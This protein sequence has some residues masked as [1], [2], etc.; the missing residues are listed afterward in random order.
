[1]IFNKKYNN[2]DDNNLNEFWSE[3]NVNYDSINEKTLE[4]KKE[5]LDNILRRTDLKSIKFITKYYNI[6]V[7]GN[8]KDDY[9]K[10]IVDSGEYLLIY[11]D[12]FIKRKKRSVDEFFNH[13]IIDNKTSTAQSTISKVF[14]I[15]NNN[16]SDLFQILTL[17]EWNLKGSGYELK[18]NKK[19]KSWDI[20]EKLILNESETTDFTE[21]LYKTS[22]DDRQYKLRS[23]YNIDKNNYIL[24]L[25]K[26]SNDSQRVDFDKSKRLKDVDKI[27]LK[28]NTK[29]DSIHIKCK[30]K[31]DMQLIKQYFEQELN[32]RFDIYE[33]EP[34]DKY[35]KD[36]F[37]ATFLDKEKIYSSELKD[38]VIDKIVFGESLLDR[39]PELT[40]NLYKKNIWTS[41]VNAVSMGIVNI[42]SL[43]AIKYMNINYKN[44]SKSIRSYVT[45]DGSVI[46]KLMDNSLDK[47]IKNEILQKF[48]LFFGI[49]LNRKILDKLDKGIAYNID[50]ILRV[51]DKEKLSPLLFSTYEE[52][53]KEKFI[54]VK[55]ERKYL[56]ENKDCRHEIT[57]DISKFKECP[58]CGEDK[59]TVECHTESNINN[60]AVNKKIL[61]MLASGLDID[62]KKIKTPKLTINNT[63]L[64]VYRFILE[65]KLYQVL[66]LNNG[67][68]SKTLKEL[69][70]QIIP[71]IIIYYG[72]ENNIAKELTLSTMEY[73]QF[74]SLYVNKEDKNQLKNII[75]SAIDS[76]NHRTHH[77]VV[78]AATTANDNLKS[79]INKSRKSYTYNDLEDDV[80]AVLKDIFYNSDKWGREYIGKSVPEGVFALNYRETD[81]DGNE[82]KHAF[83]Y[84]CKLTKHSKGYDVDKGEQRKAQDYVEKLNNTSQIK[85]YCS[86]KFLS[87][88]VFVGND[89]RDTQIEGIKKHFDE[90]FGKNRT[91]AMFINIKDLLKIHDWYRYNYEDIK[92]N[93]NPFYENLYNAF[94]NDSRL[95][96]EE[97]I[98]ELFEETS[99]YFTNTQL[100]TSKLKEKLLK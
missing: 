13:W 6:S 52:L 69:E 36:K 28:I 95:I 15:Y 29:E 27:L 78:S 51:V 93:I 72:V 62:K 58:K 35:D 68:S 31:K 65:D 34:Y 45:D 97:E 94:T 25:Y 92:N 85:S 50:F 98:N 100:N 22:Q 53:C 10:A 17:D 66:V 90:K 80:Y 61:E 39:S 89:F 99:E 56:C 84:D 23:F 32:T 21:Y 79:F 9:I 4:I 8:S 54:E 57:E 74:G 7:Q 44:V 30:S 37:K 38:F 42:E 48:E 12:K 18:S 96:G 40:L 91:K 26:L 5:E 88:H 14:D 64:D 46:F 77:H 87:A 71:T 73:I 63:D 76:V 75:D 2:L 20:L 24:M 33:G 70:K 1:M 41:V 55:T 47:D 81:V 59:Y 43:S 3:L 19:A 67:I 82:K 83:S 86:D 60:K 49:P 16:S 11:L